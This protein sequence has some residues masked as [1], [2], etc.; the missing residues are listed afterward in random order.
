M[1]EIVAHAATESAERLLV[2]RILE[3]VHR[4]TGADFRLYRP[5]TMRRRIGN[6]MIHVG[7]ATLS[8]Y[9][10][11]L[12]ANQDEAGSLLSR[13]TIK[14]SR[15][16]RNASTFD[17]LRAQVIPELAQSRAPLRIWS[18]GC[19]RGEEAYTLAM[20]L[21]D[22]G[23]EGRIDATDIDPDALDRAAAATYGA[24]AFEEL[25]ADLRARYVVPPAPDGVAKYRVCEC[26][27][28]RVRY[29]RQ[30]VTR[31]RPVGRG[32]DLVLFR[33]V[34]IYLAR[35]PQQRVFEG[36]ASA[37]RPG[38]YLCLGEAEWPPV[39]VERRLE[40]VA[41]KLKLFRATGDGMRRV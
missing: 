24:E 32:Y 13:L 31:N 30:D 37:L 29:S 39:H 11:Y 5:P 4:C 14:V 26:V 21:V 28:E 22:A 25:P 16:Y 2:E 35:E 41:R 15:F 17:R 40:C 20:L 27:R 23:I 6:R 19:G 1:L 9:L 18:A 33:N 8:D 3:V 38:G 34:A 36:V 7:K 10:E 12:E